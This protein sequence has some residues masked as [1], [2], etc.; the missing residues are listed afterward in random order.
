MSELPTGLLQSDNSQV[1]WTNLHV[2]HILQVRVIG[3]RQ[4]LYDPTPISLDAVSEEDIQ[5]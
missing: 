4:R 1:E 2:G 5:L 3:F